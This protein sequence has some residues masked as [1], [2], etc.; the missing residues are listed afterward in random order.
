MNDISHINSEMY[1]KYVVVS[2]QAFPKG[3]GLIVHL[4]LLLLHSEV[5]NLRLI[6]KHPKLE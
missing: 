1:S 5:K 6:T 3:E 2:V 4:M